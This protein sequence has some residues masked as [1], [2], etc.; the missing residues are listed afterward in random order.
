VL[1]L[2]KHVPLNVYSRRHLKY[3]RYVSFSL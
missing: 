3:E 2:T 1:F